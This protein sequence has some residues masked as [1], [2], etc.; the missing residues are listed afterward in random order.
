MDRRIQLLWKLAEAF[1]ARRPVRD[2][3]YPK[4]TNPEHWR[5]INGAHV[6]I[7]K[8]GNYDGG[9]GG[10]FNGRHHYGPDWSEKTRA[11]KT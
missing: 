10:K 11:M 4:D 6:H 8:S 3:T 2:K 5:T 7:D 1:G 9:A